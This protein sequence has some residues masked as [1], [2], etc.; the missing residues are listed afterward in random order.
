MVDAQPEPLPAGRPARNVL[1]WLA[2][3]PGV[4]ARSEVAALLWPDVLDSSARTSL[5][6]ALVKVTRCVGPGYVIATRETVG[7]DAQCVEVDLG[8]FWTAVDSE[9]LAEAWDVGR[10]PLLPG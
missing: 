3:H 8:R 9:R 6:S 5:R 10:G 2:V 4:H 1:G 7:L